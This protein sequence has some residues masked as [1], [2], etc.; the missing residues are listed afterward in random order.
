MKNT[1][2]N[3]HLT[4]KNIRKNNHYQIINCNEFSILFK[5]VGVLNV[6]SVKCIIKKLFL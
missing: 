6:Q 5:E 1:S 4:T 3:R 2:L